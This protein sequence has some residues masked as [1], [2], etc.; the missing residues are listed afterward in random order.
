MPLH[1][2][3][4]PGAWHLVYTPVRTV[5]MG[6]HLFLYDTMH[7]T[8]M[9]RRFDHKHAR[10]VTNTTHISAFDTLCLMTIHLI[11]SDEIG[12]ALYNAV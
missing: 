11:R 6:G 2:I 9:S 4:P 12:K 1:R 3:M 8:E 10:E 7:F 5:A